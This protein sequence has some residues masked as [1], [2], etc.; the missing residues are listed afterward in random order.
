M[1]RIV[2]IIPYDP[3]WPER[4][5]R[6]AEALSGVFGSAAKAIHHIGSTSVPGLAAKPV[7]DILVVLEDTSDV[8]RFDQAM[9]A[10]GYRVRGECLDAG[11]TPGRFYY[12][13]PALGKRTHHVH[14]C[15]DGHFQ[16]PELLLFPRYL[17]DRPDVAV[18]YA[19][20]KAQALEEGG[21]DNAEYMA[22]KHRWIRA[23]VR[24]ALAH[25]RE[26]D[27]RPAFEPGA[28]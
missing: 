4:F 17:R 25:F 19:E 20:L 28:P 2:E 21:G 3:E 1:S 15:A 23:A 9:V 12:N 22:M 13:K 6:E 24:D 27:R 18:A 16:I 5:A 11:G 8:T 26:R 14:V 10:L 7:I